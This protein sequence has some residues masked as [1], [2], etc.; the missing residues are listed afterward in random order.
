MK[1]NLETT[2]NDNIAE[3]FTLTLYSSF[4]NAVE[5]IKIKNTDTDKQSS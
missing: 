4:F 2:V 5:I 3:L 1:M